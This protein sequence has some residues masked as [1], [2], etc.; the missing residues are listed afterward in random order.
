MGT[1]M[2]HYHVLMGLTGGCMPNSNAM[3]TSRRAAE[4]YA[5]ALANEAVNAGDT[6]S[7][8]AKSGYYSIGDSECI[9]IN[10][11]YEDDCSEDDSEYPNY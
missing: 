6:V 10:D 2:R 8:S 5:A 7:G 11:C 4:I 3:F 1:A 9:E